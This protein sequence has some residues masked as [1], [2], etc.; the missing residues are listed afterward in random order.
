MAYFLGFVSNWNAVYPRTH[1]MQVQWLREQGPTCENTLSAPDSVV[2]AEGFPVAA[3]TYEL[4]P[5]AYGSREAGEVGLWLTATF[6]NHNGHL[7]TPDGTMW[8]YRQ[9]G[10]PNY[11]SAGRSHLE[12]I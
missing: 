1:P 9:V 11:Y 7:V 10:Q 12:K 5:G 4:T 2:M 3:G 6:V 8:R